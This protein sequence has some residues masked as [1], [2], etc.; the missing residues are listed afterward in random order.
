[1]KIVSTCNISYFMFTLFSKLTSRQKVILPSSR[2]GESEDASSSDSISVW[3]RLQ[4]HPDGYYL[5]PWRIYLER[6][7]L[8]QTLRKDGHKKAV[9]KHKAKVL[10][11]RGW[12]RY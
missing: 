10:A 2:R 5:S 9:L 6:E 11:G 7:E 3:V 12:F 1:M 4:R 8:C